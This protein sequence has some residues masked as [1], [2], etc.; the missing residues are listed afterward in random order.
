MKQLSTVARIA[1]SL[2]LAAA[3]SATALTQA[4]RPMTIVDMIDIPSLGDPQ[5]SPFCRK[6]TGKR[7]SG[8]APSGASTRTAPSGSG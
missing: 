3:F 7:T 8:L 4:K 5:L 6:R 1:G 2:A